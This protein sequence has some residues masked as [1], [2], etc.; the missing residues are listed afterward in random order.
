MRETKDYDVLVY[1]AACY[2]FV[3]YFVFATVFFFALAS[4]CFMAC[5]GCILQ[6]FSFFLLLECG[7]MFLILESRASRA[8][9]AISCVI[10]S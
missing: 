1:S 3:W 8:M 6:C 7:V 4:A 9:S 5:W 10:L 2:F